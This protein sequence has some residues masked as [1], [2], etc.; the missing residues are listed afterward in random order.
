MEYAFTFWACF[1]LYREYANV[2]AM[3]LQ[4]MAAERRRPDQFS[5]RLLVVL[6]GYCFCFFFAFY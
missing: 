1:I 2:A 6:S 3:R 4:F 5:V